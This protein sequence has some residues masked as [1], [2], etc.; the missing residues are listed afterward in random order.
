MGLIRVRRRTRAEY[1]IDFD[2]TN[3]LLSIACR[4]RDAAAFL[5]AMK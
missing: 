5:A 3:H 2:L 4:P 1:A